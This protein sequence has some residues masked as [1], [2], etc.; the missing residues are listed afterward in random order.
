MCIRDSFEGNHKL[1][2]RRHKLQESL[3]VQPCNK[4]F[5]G[6]DLSK[7]T[8]DHQNFLLKQ[9]RIE[10]DWRYIE[11]VNQLLNER[12]NAVEEEAIMLCGMITKLMLQQSR[13]VIRSCLSQIL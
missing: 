4:S 9:H 7:S 13:D 1:F 3:G 8:S 6:I 10:K 12:Y 11:G 2:T 5:V